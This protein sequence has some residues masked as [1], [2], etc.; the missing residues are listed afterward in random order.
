MLAIDKVA[1]SKVKIDGRN[2]WQVLIIDDKIIPRKVELIKEK[3]GTDH[4]ISPKE[5]ALLLSKNPEVILV[6]NGWSGVLKVD[7]SFKEQALK[8]GIELKVVLTPRIKKA[9][10]QLVKEKKR[11][12]ALIHTTC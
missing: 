10:N 3:Y 2:F 6:A 7:E 4:L 5:Q 12:N 8:S 1:W 9:Y 11:V